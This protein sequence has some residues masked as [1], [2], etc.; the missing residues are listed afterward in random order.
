MR[1]L[2][3]Q[4][5]VEQCELGEDVAD[6]AQGQVLVGI[7]GGMLELTHIKGCEVLPCKPV[8]LNEVDD[9]GAVGFFL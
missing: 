8:I 5:F 4:R 1:V 9:L 2:R 7:Q 6:F 3:A